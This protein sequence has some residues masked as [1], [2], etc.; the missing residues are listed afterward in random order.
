MKGVGSI[1]LLSIPKHKKSTGKFGRE[2]S[3][4]VTYTTVEHVPIASKDAYCKYVTRR[5]IKA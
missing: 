4:S 1:S 3:V 5:I 2:Q